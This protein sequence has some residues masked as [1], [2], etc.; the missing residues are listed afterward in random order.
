VRLALAVVLALASTGCRSGAATV[1]MGGHGRFRIGALADT[2]GNA[3][4]TMANL[5][6]FAR[7]FKDEHVDAV[8]VLGDL[9]ET[10]REIERVL[11]TIGSVPA[12][13]L[14]LPG[15]RE[16]GNEFHSAVT[17]VR[18]SGVRIVDLVDNRFIDTGEIDIVAVPGYPFSDR[19]YRY[20]AGDLA[21]ARA[22][23][24]RRW[25]PLV[26][27]AHT[28]P[29][30]NG[31]QS[32]DWATGEV[33]AGDGGMTDLCNAVYPN[34]ALFAHVDEAGG[35]NERS[36]INVG[37]VESGMAGIVEIERGVARHRVLR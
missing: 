21:R 27:L 12:P 32:I 9:G 23:A 20:D 18:N 16:R 36:W 34:A 8:A 15:E 19:G 2:N 30:G 5:S 7:V 13:L 28:P 22:L 31:E 17:R 6:R 1:K 24:G 26:L 35:R 33:N 3:P 29:K 14:V 37:G 11:S 10:E 4:A 25:R